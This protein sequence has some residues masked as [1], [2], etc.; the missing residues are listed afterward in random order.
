M[1]STV[2]WSILFAAVVSI[3]IAFTIKSRFRKQFHWLETPGVI[4]Q[5]EVKFDTD[6][7]LPVISY[8]YTFQ[9]RCFTGDTVRSGNL[10][11]NWSGP[12]KR[13][14]ARYPQGSRVS[15]RVNPNNPSQSVLEPGGHAGFVPFVLVLATF[16]II[17]ASLVLA[18]K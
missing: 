8:E 12:A 18:G 2:A 16:M 11:Y 15:V 1:S 13:L 4:T 7:Y 14:C 17:V 10:T 5:S 9:S 3:G 6:E